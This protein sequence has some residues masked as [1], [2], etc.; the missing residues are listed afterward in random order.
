MTTA[1]PGGGART[2]RGWPQ[3]RGSLADLLPPAVLALAAV[4][5]LLY[6]HEP[7]A[8]WALT[9]A[10]VLPLAWRR[11]A[12]L[13][14][15]A[16]CLLC[17]LVLWAVRVP[18]LG[19]LGVLVALYTVATYRPLPVSL[20]SAAALEFGVVLSAFRFAPA[21][22]VDDAVVLLSG[23]GA[24][25]LFLGTTVRAHRRYLSSVE[26]R[27]RRLEREQAQQAELAAAAERARIAR[28]L[29]DIVAHGLSVM[30]SMA[31]GAAAS[32]RTDPPAAQ[33]AM[34]QVAVSGRQSLAEM[35]SLLGV[36]RT[37]GGVDRAP[38]PGLDRLVALAD[39]VRRTGLQVELVEHG[40]R[41]LV[42]PTAQTTVFRI[43]QE[44]LTNVVKHAP[45]AT[46][47]TIVLD[48]LPGEV[49]FAITDDG[50]RA[51]TDTRD[52]EGNGL[53]GIRERLAVFGGTMAAV[54]ATTGWTL[55]GEL[56]LGGPTVTAT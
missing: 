21:G 40:P 4:H 12:P 32:M 35:R 11:R 31:E 51:D 22:S 19:D 29:H 14:V 34:R 1:G 16:V 7:L 55:R 42:G 6:N 24:A 37:D 50:R 25:S 47:T 52:L 5:E 27:A 9:T 49:R 17:A 44:A 8:V 33:D 54:R 38:Q 10:V 56:P 30:I 2:V 13:T 3:V 48:Y 41:D 53:T 26:D 45:T 15:F 36:L 43:V 39:D 28:E 46:R 23:M 18:T 20:G